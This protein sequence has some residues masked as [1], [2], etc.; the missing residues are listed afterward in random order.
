MITCPR[1]LLERRMYLRRYGVSTKNTRDRR[2]SQVKPVS[3]ECLACHYSTAL[4]TTKEDTS[5][6]MEMILAKH[7]EEEEMHPYS[8]VID[9]VSY[10]LELIPLERIGNPLEYSAEVLE[11]HRYVLSPFRDYVKLMINTAFEK[12]TKAGCIPT[13]TTP[14]VLLD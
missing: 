5:D 7:A 8:T 1:L 11:L 6:P 14:S 12:S 4:T 9:P 2:H 13:L 10:D 3:S